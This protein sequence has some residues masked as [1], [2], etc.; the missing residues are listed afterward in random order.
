[1]VVVKVSPLINKHQDLIHELIGHNIQIYKYVFI[2]MKL[3]TQH[4]NVLKEDAFLNMY[5]SEWI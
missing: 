1:M 5:K 2:F 4:T 3:N